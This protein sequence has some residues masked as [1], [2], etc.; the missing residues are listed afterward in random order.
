MN[1][2]C[3]KLVSCLLL[4]STVAS[5]ADEAAENLK[6]RLDAY[7]EA[8]RE[9]DLRR[10][11]TFILPS[12][13]RKLGGERAYLRL[14]EQCKPV[15]GGAGV[16]VFKMEFGEP[17]PIESLK[18][19]IFTIEGKEVTRK[20]FLVAVIP[21]K[22][23][24]DLG[25]AKGVMRGALVAVSGDDGEHWHFVEGNETTERF[26][27]RD[28]SA[29]AASIHIPPETIE[30][31]KGHEKAY[32][33]WKRGKWAKG[34]PDAATRPRLKVV[35][36]GIYAAE[37]DAL[38]P[39]MGAT[40]GVTVVSEELVH[41]KT[42]RVVSAKAG[43]TFG[44]RSIIT[45][46]QKG[47][48][49]TIERRKRYPPLKQPDGSVVNSAGGTAT[50]RPG[51]DSPGALGDLFHFLEGYEYEMVPGDWVFEASIDGEEAVSITFKVVAAKRR[52]EEGKAP[53][54]PPDERR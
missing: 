14:M 31:T 26:L 41:V 51:K 24:I 16:D 13:L 12:L 25:D 9:R 35:D 10:L 22:L 7:T 15:E 5:C 49:Y 37:V 20:K 1:T 34:S 36:Y 32:L 11:A 47:R 43:V 54:L 18:S 38:K 19:L 28:V 8:L 6:A 46:G 39:T 17:G 52:K 33:V 21:K 53:E 44:Y 29:L 45:G 42:T 50:Y 30:I 27:I 23:D 2:N 40:G 3:P 48:T 4:L